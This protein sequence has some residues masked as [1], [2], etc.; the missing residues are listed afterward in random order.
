MSNQTNIFN[1]LNFVSDVVG[2]KE[3]KVRQIRFFRY[4]D[5]SLGIAFFDDQTI[6]SEYWLENISVPHQYELI[7]NS[8]GLKLDRK[9]DLSLFGLKAFSL[10][11]NSF[12]LLTVQKRLLESIFD[13]IQ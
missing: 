11:K 4:E 5:G 12:Q 1:V 3:R 9:Y 6:Y 8:S 13:A 7:F 2:I 10:D